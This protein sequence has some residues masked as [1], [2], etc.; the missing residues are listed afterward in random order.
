MTTDTQRA[1]MS[2]AE[3]STAAKRSETA[4]LYTTQLVTDY[5]ALLDELE[6][7]QDLL[8]ELM[9]TVYP[10]LDVRTGLAYDPVMVQTAHNTAASY[11]RRAALAS[12]AGDVSEGEA[13]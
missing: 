10:L 4:M 1:R 12:A 8:R 3:A 6:V 9:R 11:L 5:I 7:A 13:E 2:R